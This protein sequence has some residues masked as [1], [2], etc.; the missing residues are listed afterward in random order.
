MTH[1]L[2]VPSLIILL[3]FSTS[4]F[5]FNGCSEDTSK[6]RVSAIEYYNQAYIA[7]EDGF[8]QEAEKNFQTLIEDHP[9][10]RLSTIA[11]LKLGDL[12]FDIITPYFS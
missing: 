6:V 12:N 1:Y 9:N 5:F 7:L 8:L 10:T 4:Q 2:K 11:Y 3:F